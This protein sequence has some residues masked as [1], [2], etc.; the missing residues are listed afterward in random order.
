MLNERIVQTAY[1]FRMNSLW[2]KQVGLE[3][4]ESGNSR[5]VQFHLPVILF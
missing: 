4:V 1:L 3:V 5:Q 2:W